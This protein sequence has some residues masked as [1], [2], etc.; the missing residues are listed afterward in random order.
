ML[1]QPL[2]G[3]YVSPLAAIRR[4]R[5]NMIQYVPSWGKGPV[6][7]SA[8]FLAFYSLVFNGLHNNRQLL[9]WGVINYGRKK[10]LASFT[11]PAMSDSSLLL[12]P[13]SLSKAPPLS[14]CLS[15]RFL[16]SV[17]FDTSQI[18]NRGSALTHLVPESSAA[19]CTSRYLSYFLRWSFQDGLY[20]F[21]GPSVISKGILLKVEHNCLGCPLKDPFGYWEIFHNFRKH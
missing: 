7:C 19:G 15:Y 10:S 8:L 12:L 18:K 5:Y 3:Q 16:L 11:S 1:W 2:P 13:A 6:L 4:T 17:I 14:S 20:W 21:T 9:I